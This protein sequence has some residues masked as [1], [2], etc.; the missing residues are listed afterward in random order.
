MEV[1]G[2]HALAQIVEHDGARG[3]AKPTKGLC[4]LL[5]DL[6]VGLTRAGLR[7]S[8]GRNRRLIRD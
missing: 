7:C 5:D 3:A 6:S 2:E 1:G 8:A 4:T